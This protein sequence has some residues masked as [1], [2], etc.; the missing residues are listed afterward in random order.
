MEREEAID[1]VA[2]GGDVVAFEQ[3]LADQGAAVVGVA[4]GLSEEERVVNLA[5]V[6]QA[7]VAE[8]VV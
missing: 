4:H 3:E 1:T 7:K 6:C 5:V 8:D 2:E